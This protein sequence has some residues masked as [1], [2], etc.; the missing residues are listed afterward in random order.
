[1]TRE[2]LAQFREVYDKSAKK[3]Q[4]AKGFDGKEIEEQT[5]WVFFDRDLIQKLLDMTDKKSGGIKM[6]F[7]QYDKENLDL[8]PKDRKLREDYE[9]RVSLALAAANREG[10]EIIDVDDEV[11]QAR[12]MGGGSGGG[13][14][15]NGGNICPPSCN[16]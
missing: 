6:Y 11:I 13:G 4:K 1:M 16:R 12:G 5:D 15:Q 2:Q 7:G 9:G 8:I 10:E 3:F 14:T